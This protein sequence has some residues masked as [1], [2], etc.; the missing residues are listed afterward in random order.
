VCINL[1][2]I[3]A[4]ADSVYCLLLFDNSVLT[5]ASVDCSFG[6]S[7]EFEFF[8]ICESLAHLGDRSKT[9]TL[10]EMRQALIQ[11]NL[12]GVYSDEVFKEQ[13]KLIEEQIASIRMTKDDELV[14]KYNI[15]SVVE[16]MRAKFSDLGKTYQESNV[17]QIKVLLGSIFPSG[18]VW[19]YPGYSN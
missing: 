17:T 5:I 19:G 6:L 7:M 15:Q 16:F 1:R 14:N 8:L 10:Y 11:K 4:C 13:N 3:S 12:S 9:I 18:M 2:N